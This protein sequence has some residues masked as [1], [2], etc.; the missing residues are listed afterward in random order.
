VGE[1]GV[2]PLDERPDE[3]LAM[4]SSSGDKG[5]Y[6]ILVCRHMRRVFAVC[7]A[8]LGDLADA[9]DAVQEVFVKGLKGI[10]TLRD[11]RQFEGWISQIARN[12]CRDQLRRHSRRRQV[13]LTEATGGTTAAQEDDFASLR[14]AI[15]RLPEHFRLPLLLYYYDGKST[16]K[17]AEDLNLTQ[18]G[19][20]TR[21][22]RARKELRKLL[23]E[24]AMRDA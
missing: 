24:E 17:L 6:G 13:P 19:A 16:Q 2:I 15:G 5:A 11:S 21:L 12:H 8:M 18:G 20:C 14:G 7:L 22:Y 3:Q 9:E 23:D 1:Q 4:A 10:H